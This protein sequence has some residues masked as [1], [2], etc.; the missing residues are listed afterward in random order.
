[1]LVTTAWLADRIGAGDIRLIDARYHPLDP[2]R[3]PRREYEAGHLPGAIFMDQ[4]A[5]ADPDSPLPS[6]LPDDARFAAALSAMGVATDDRIVVYD[7]GGYH[8]GA[9]AW[10]ML[11]L[12]G[13]RDVALL[14]GG[15]DRWRAEGRPIETGGSPAGSARFVARRDP[16]QVRD[17]AQMR[18]N[19]TVQAEQ[20]VDARSAGRFTG[21]DPDP[22]PGMAAGHIPGSRNLPYGALFEPDGTWK[23]GVALAQAFAAAGVDPARPTVFTCGSGIT[24]AVLLF[25][26]TLLGMRELA[27]Y[28]GSWSEWGADPAT[29]KATGPAA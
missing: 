23:R 29:P 7:D 27:L 13:A 3:D 19:L 8:T 18:A 20:V 12:F 17:L 21:A 28:D 14:D 5:I 9:R 11:R 6:T 2:S 16:A 10:W 24:A 22:R 26:A 25:G 1:M 15:L 4:A